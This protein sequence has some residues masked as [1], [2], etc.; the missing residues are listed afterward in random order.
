MS[1]E[2]NPTDEIIV[3]HLVCWGVRWVSRQLLG[4]FI[5]NQNAISHWYESPL[6]LRL[7]ILAPNSHCQTKH[8]DKEAKQ[9]SHSKQ[10][11]SFY[12]ALVRANLRCGT[13]VAFLI[14]LRDLVTMWALMKTLNIV[15]YVSGEKK[16]SKE[17][18]TKKEKEERGRESWNDGRDIKTQE[19]WWNKHPPTTDGTSSL[20]TEILRLDLVEHLTGLGAALGVDDSQDAL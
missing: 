12:S 3:V 19:S 9:Q 8:K 2:E 15:G 6:I 1:W 18:A 5:K 20:G 7:F 4:P 17:K 14:C 16:R 11:S 13:T 10:C